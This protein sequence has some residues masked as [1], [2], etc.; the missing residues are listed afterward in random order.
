MPPTV[1]RVAAAADPIV[2]RTAFSDAAQ[3]G[4]VPGPRRPDGRRPAGAVVDAGSVYVAFLDPSTYTT[5]TTV[6]YDD[7]EGS[8]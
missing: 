5:L 8:G 3:G 2:L 6:T 1:G 7:A 4:D